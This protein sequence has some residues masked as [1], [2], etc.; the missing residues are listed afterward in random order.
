VKKSLALTT[1]GATNCNPAVAIEAI[2]RTRTKHNNFFIIV[3]LSQL[4]EQS[5][6][7]I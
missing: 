5:V 1:G 3:L 2:P 7:P 4:F 6:V